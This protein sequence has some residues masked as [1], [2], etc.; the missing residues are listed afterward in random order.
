MLDKQVLTK[1][2]AQPGAQLDA[3]MLYGAICGYFGG[4]QVSLNVEAVGKGI[5]VHN[6]LRS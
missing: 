4:A 5:N 6:T 3:K 1:K 2:I